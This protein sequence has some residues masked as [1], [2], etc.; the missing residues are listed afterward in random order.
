MALHG[1]DRGRI[2]VEQQRTLEHPIR[3]RIWSLFTEDPA[4]S[5][6]AIA[7]H[8]DLVEEG[9]FRDLTVSQVSY[10]LARLQDA[11]LVPVPAEG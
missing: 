10:H 7:L 2:E 4:R 8:G 1:R 5:P 9:K 3:F 11:E 6:T